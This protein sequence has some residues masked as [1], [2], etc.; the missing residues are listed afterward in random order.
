MFGQMEYAPIIPVSA[1][2]GSGFDKLLN[3]AL[4]MYK[5]LNT[6]VGTSQLNQALE[7]WLAEY[8]PPT[9]PRTRFK[10]KYAVQSSANPVKF[11]FFVSRQAAVSES[12]ISYLRNKI[13]ADL[14]FSMIP[15]LVELR[16]SDRDTKKT[17][18]KHP[19]AKVR[20][21]GNRDRKN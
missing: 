3:T 9:G 1:L 11:L 15:V 13:R 19:A 10:V 20:R 7:R 14:G 2:N 17:P 21:T 5:Q 18:E 12:Y 16:M 6:R 8:P 4:R